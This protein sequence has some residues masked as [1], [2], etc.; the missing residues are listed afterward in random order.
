MLFAALL[1]LRCTSYNAI[2]SD[3]HTRSRCR[4][5]R[6]FLQNSMVLAKL[7]GS[8]RTRRFLQNSTVLAELDGSCGYRRFSQNS[9]CRCISLLSATT[10]HIEKEKRDWLDIQTR[11]A[12]D[13]ASRNGL[14]WVYRIAKKMPGTAK[15]GSGP[16]KVKYG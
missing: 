10:P 5:T 13:V 8:C 3:N 15:T 14:I 7:D 4:R 1:R 2:F 16:N 9:F 11:E 12:K 6:R